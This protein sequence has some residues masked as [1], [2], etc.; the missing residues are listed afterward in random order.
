MPTR[1][2][3]VGDNPVL[4]S[5]SAEAS[6]KTTMRLA[7]AGFEV[8]YYALHRAQPP[9]L[10]EGITLLPTFPFTG[11]AV[12]AAGLGGASGFSYV[13]DT[14]KPDIIVTC[15]HL[16]QLTSLAYVLEQRESGLPWHH[17]PTPEGTTF[18][19]PVP[20]YANFQRHDRPYPVNPMFHL[21]S[22]R[23][24]ARERSHARD[25][26]V[27]GSLP[28]NLPRTKIA[29]VLS[30]LARMAT[31]R[32]LLKLLWVEDIHRR[33][34]ESFRDA[35]KAY[36]TLEY[37][38]AY[39]ENLSEDAISLPFKALNL[40]LNAADVFLSFAPDGA[41][42]QAALEAACTG[43]PVLKVSDPDWPSQLA[44]IYDRR[45]EYDRKASGDNA[46]AI[47]H[48]D[49]CARYWLEL[50]AKRPGP[51]SV[52]LAPRINWYGTLFGSGS[53]NHVTREMVLALDRCGADVTI[54][55]PFQ[56][57]EKMALFPDG[58]E[59][60]YAQRNPQEYERLIALRNKRPH[61]APFTTVRFIVSR[62]EFRKFELLRSL[63]Q[64]VIEYSN[65]DNPGRQSADAI[66]S[67]LEGKPMWVVSEYVKAIYSAAGGFPASELPGLVVVHHGVAPDVFHPGVEPA[68]LGTGSKFTFLNCSFPRIQHKGLDRLCEAYCS[69]FAGNPDVSLVLKLPNRR[70]V[71]APG[72]YEEV[73]RL[74]EKMRSQSDCPEIRIIEA[75]TPGRGDLARYY[76][77]ADAYVHPSRWEA[78]SI[79][80]LESLAVGL[81]LIVTRWGG[82]REFCPEDMAYYVDCQPSATDFGRT[83]EP[84]LA[85][86]RQQ[87]RYVYEHREEARRRGERASRHVRENFTWDHA[88]RRMIALVT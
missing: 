62:P 76:R 57:F 64:P 51:A 79:S 60:N 8:F 2:L 36:P 87:M 46:C 78:C 56:R 41:V 50:F 13:L 12:A 69:E 4:P 66:R 72:E 43:A 58:F 7:Q 29:K 71:V 81:P 82:H 18:P 11:D 32:P 23:S 3:W 17:W 33:E 44:D 16:S 40:Y 86:L 65:S 54:E 25:R 6:R 83:A 14:V 5:L 55:E 24:E 34:I 9:T 21:L 80:L 61:D 15:G 42:D 30:Q 28:R 70:V 10:W 37:H 48:A 52:S 88:A 26:F 38:R 77:A 75:D 85:S 68:D 59:S 39:W 35:I 20:E 45:A 74:I 67:R 27:V 63:K 73:D 31:E 49:A 22:D 84:E 47:Y 1:L 19:E 53:V